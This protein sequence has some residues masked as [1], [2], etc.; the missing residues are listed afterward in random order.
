VEERGG[1]KRRIKEEEK[2]IKPMSCGTD[3][4]RLRCKPRAGRRA[5]KQ[6]GASA[7]RRVKKRKEGAE[8]DASDR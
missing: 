2:K 8:G 4:Q 5:E 3:M 6:K 7:K 1:E